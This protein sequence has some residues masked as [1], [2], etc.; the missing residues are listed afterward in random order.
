MKYDV[1][2]SYSRKDSEVVDKIYD[3][4]EGAGIHCFIDRDGI[5][6][7][8][9][10]PM[11]LAEAIME[12]KLLLL[13]ASENSYQSDFT[14]KE[15]TFAVSNKGSSFIFPLIVDGSKMPPK[16]EF[17]LSD[18]NWRNL[19][20][21][22]RI[23]KELVEDVKHKLAN[24][25]AGETLQQREKGS[26]KTFFILILLL[27]IGGGGG[28]FWYQSYQEKQR[29]EKAAAEK[30]AAYADE[31]QCKQWIEECK[32]CLYTADTLKAQNRPFD[33]FEAEV[34]VLQS[35][36]PIANKAD[37]LKATYNDNDTYRQRFTNLTTNYVRDRQ[38]HKLDSMYNYWKRFAVSNY[39][40]F[41]A[42]PYKGYKDDALDCAR[43]ALYIN[44]DDANLLEIQEYLNSK[45]AKKK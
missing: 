20:H 10:F 8:A 28:L 6:G 32:A 17:L 37:S 13:V 5:S 3:A 16:L 14:Q 23:D 35:M 45:T 40:E 22:Y 36:T 24:P 38:Q 43:R 2:I 25:H 44:P 26:A 27:M 30:A 12:S 42:Y 7:G 15:L 33:T 4:L 1:F 9:D 41:R 31:K 19:G 21:S 34:D 11:I 18:I 39:E 29:Q